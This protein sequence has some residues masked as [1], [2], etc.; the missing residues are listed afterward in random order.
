[1]PGAHWLETLQEKNSTQIIISY[2][3][4]VCRSYGWKIVKIRAEK[5]GLVRTSKPRELH[6]TLRMTPKHGK[7][8]ELEIGHHKF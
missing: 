2:S 5:F 7:L 8:E 3:Y 1:M 6:N 4:S